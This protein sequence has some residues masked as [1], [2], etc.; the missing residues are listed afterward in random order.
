MP[1]E[2]GSA[3]LER[4]RM[5]V[6]LADVL[7]LGVA[8]PDQVLYD[9]FDALVD[10]R[11]P[12]VHP[13]EVVDARDRADDRVLDGQHGKSG[14]SAVDGAGGLV[15]R[16]VPVSRGASYE[17]LGDFLAERARLALKR[18]H[19]CVVRRHTGMLAAAPSRNAATNARNTVR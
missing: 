12:L 11:Q 17:L 16:A 13:Q 4:D 15:E 9:A 2:E 7:D 18:D 19:L 1:G 5:R 14:L 10:D 6:H 3:L 8:G